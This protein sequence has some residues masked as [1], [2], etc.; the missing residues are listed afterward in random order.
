MP[1][2][3][4]MR[5][6]SKQYQFPWL[7]ARN[8]HNAKVLVKSL[9]TTVIVRQIQEPQCLPFN[10]FFFWRFVNNQ[11]WNGQYRTTFWSCLNGFTKFFDVSSQNERTVSTKRWLLTSSFHVNSSLVPPPSLFF[12]LPTPWLLGLNVFW[13]QWQGSHYAFHD[14]GEEINYCPTV[15]YLHWFQIVVFLWDKIQDMHFLSKR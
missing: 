15:I 8:Q 6:I 1:K 10:L 2:S 4:T 12:L 3:R 13:L 5:T 11:F 9:T 14:T 7:K